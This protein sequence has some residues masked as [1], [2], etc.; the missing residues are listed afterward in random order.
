MLCAYA[1]ITPSAILH[2]VVIAHGHG[3]QGEPNQT[4]AAFAQLYTSRLSESRTQKPSTESV[5][6]A[7]ELGDDNLVIKIS[8]LIS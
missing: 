3:S 6:K 2:A 1:F 4:A 7:A 8:H 5:A